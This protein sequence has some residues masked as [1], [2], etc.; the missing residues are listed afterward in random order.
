MLNIKTSCDWKQIVPFS[1][2]HSIS[3]IRM[4][5]HEICRKD[6]KICSIVL[7]FIYHLCVCVC[8]CD[9]TGETIYYFLLSTFLNRHVSKIWFQTTTIVRLSNLQIIMND[10]FVF[11]YHKMYNRSK[12]K[13]K[14]RN[15]PIYFN[16]NYCTEVKLFLRGA[17]T[18]GFPT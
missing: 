18:W 12:R 16:T 14:K 8:V 9:T 4:W 13:E 17:S 10:N 7:L 5:I 6:V 1:H 11:K 2:F 3:V 15:T